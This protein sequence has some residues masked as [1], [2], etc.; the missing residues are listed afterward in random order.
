MSYM[1]DD[2]TGTKP[3]RK[4]RSA[5]PL[6][7]ALVVLVVA[8]IAYFA[9]GMPGMDHSSSTM[10]HGM[11][12]NSSSLMDHGMTPHSSHRM[13]ESASFEAAIADTNTVA[14][15]VHVPAGA[16]AL[17]GTDLTMPFD[18]LD[19]GTLPSDRDSTL[20]VYCRSGAMSAIAVERLLALGYTNVV[21][22]EGGTDAWT[23]SGR[24]LAVATDP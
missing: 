1:I 20:A 16:V 2:V 8:V 6:V 5:T 21:E 13:M 4:G 19:A 24:S 15:N 17:N 14:I 3:E 23:A 10:D 12:S 9:T 18:D 7:I 22:L 11:T